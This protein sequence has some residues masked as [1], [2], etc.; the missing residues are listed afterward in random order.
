MPKLRDI[1]EDGYSVIRCCPCIRSVCEAPICNSI[2]HSLTFSENSRKTTFVRILFASEED[3]VLKG[4][5]K[6]QLDLGAYM[7]TSTIVQDLSS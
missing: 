7:R 6:F 2:E 5:Y 4:L 1:N 3:Q